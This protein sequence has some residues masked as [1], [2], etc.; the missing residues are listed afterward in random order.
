MWG[1]NGISK[2]ILNYFFQNKICENEQVVE[3]TRNSGAI[4]TVRES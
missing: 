4:S 3:V 2:L 1:L